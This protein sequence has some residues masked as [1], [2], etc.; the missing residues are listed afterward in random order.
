MDKHVMISEEFAGAAADCVAELRRLAALSA[1]VEEGS[2]APFFRDMAA[3][4]ELP[5][6]AQEVRSR[7]IGL[8]L[9]GAN[10]TWASA[11]D[12]LRSLEGDLRR[13]PA[14]VWSTMT[15]ARAIQES[16]VF[17]C[18]VAE[19]EISV[20]ERLV[21]IAAT[22]L[23]D[24][25]YLAKAAPAWH[26][27][28]QAAQQDRQF[29]IDELLCGGFMLNSATAPTTVGLDGASAPVKLN[30]TARAKLLL[31]PEAPEAYRLAS[32]A[33][34][35]RPWFLSGNAIEQDGAWST[36]WA[37]VV[38]AVVIAA[39][40]VRSGVQSLCGYLGLDDGQAR[41]G[42]IDATLTAFLETPAN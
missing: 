8:G 33:V 41:C 18:Y 9:S 20:H 4:R 31:S 19:P 37:T 23:Q 32:G 22:W 7:L 3:I 16:A 28:R 29:R 24:V 25:D 26:P 12:H 17:V 15:L 21:R 6:P 10:V 40:A 34:H 27:G 39:R 2:G 13:W 1:D 42:E 35:A 14:P 38:S 36:S 5:E 11:D 30:V